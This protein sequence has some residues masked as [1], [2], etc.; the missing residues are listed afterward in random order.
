MQGWLSERFGPTALDYTTESSL[1]PRYK[2]LSK[3]AQ[4]R[5]LNGVKRH[6]EALRELGLE[7]CAK[8]LADG[9]PCPNLSLMLDPK[10]GE[11]RCVGHAEALP[12]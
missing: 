6:F 5:V 8:D 3:P 9:E 7:G 10:T 12:E 2:P 4:R 1:M 11:P